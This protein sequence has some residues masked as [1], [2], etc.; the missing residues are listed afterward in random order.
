MSKTRKLLM[1]GVLAEVFYEDGIGGAAGS[2]VKVFKA[3]SATGSRDCWSNEVAMNRVLWQ[4]PSH[5]AILPCLE[6]DMVN[7]TLRFPYCVH[8]DI[9]N[10][11]LQHN[12]VNQ[13]DLKKKWISQMVEAVYHLHE[14]V[15]MAHLDLSL[16]NFM[17]TDK[18]DIKL[19]DFAQAHMLK[20]PFPFQQYMIGKTSYRAEEACN[21]VAATSSGCNIVAATSNGCH[22]Y[23]AITNLKALD[24]WALGICIYAVC[25]HGFLW[26]HVTHERYQL[27]VRDPQQFWKLTNQGSSFFTQEATWVISL[28]TGL[29][30][31]DPETRTTIC[32][33]RRRIK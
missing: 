18:L 12:P 10:Y 27:F 25:F 8:G 20:D 32:E 16:E 2:A 29:L 17:L 7:T 22:N 19:G 33:L 21:I 1:K 15:G 11:L 28:V 31:R 30:R 3:T 26:S 23:R 6:I 14:V 5:S 24:M 4:H 13:W 9:L